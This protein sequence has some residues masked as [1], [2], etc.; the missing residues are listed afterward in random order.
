MRPGA[1]LEDDFVLCE[2]PEAAENEYMKLATLSGDVVARIYT[3]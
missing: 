1:E 2:E 3:T